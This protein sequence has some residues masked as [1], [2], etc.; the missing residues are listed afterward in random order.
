MQKKEAEALVARNLLKELAPPLSASRTKSGTFSTGGE[1][2]AIDN[3]FIESLIKNNYYKTLVET[4]LK[5]ETEAKELALD[6]KFWE[7][8]IA[9]LNENRQGKN[10]NEKIGKALMLK[11]KMIVGDLSILLNEA[12]MLN[13]EYLGGVMYGSVQIVGGPDYFKTRETSL[14][15]IMLLAGVIA[16]MGSVF[17]AF[18][19]E[20]IEKYRK[21]QAEEEQEITR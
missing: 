18:F 6:K 20:F 13:Q 3:S 17:L 9:A 10:T 1:N 21:E 11:L 14:R 12:N 5:A 19:I 7:K 8:E 2:V 15:N 4:S 16:L